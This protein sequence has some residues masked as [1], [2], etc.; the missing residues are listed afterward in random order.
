ML[1][2]SFCF[3]SRWQAN[4]DPVQGAWSFLTHP[5]PIRV[6][7]AAGLIRYFKEETHGPKLSPKVVMGFAIGVIVFEVVLRFYGPL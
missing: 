3:C 1:L 6:L 2:A 7:I 5:G 4:A